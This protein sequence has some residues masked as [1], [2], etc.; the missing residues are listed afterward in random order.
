MEDLQIYTDEQ[1]QNFNSKQQLFNSTIELRKNINTLV[2][3]YITIA[4]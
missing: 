2:A 1:N 4:D 3:I